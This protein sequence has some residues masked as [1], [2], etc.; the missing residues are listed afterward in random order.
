MVAGGDAAG[1]GQTEE[2]C[3]DDKSSAGGQTGQRLRQSLV[4]E[5]AQ[6]GQGRATDQSPLRRNPK[7]LRAL[8]RFSVRLQDFR[9]KVMLGTPFLVIWLMGFIADLDIDSWLIKGVMYAAVWL[10]VQCLSKYDAVLPIC[11]AAQPFNAF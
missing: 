4:P 9:Q 10:V 11:G 2:K 5:T 7:V 8:R 6:N 3:V 1:F